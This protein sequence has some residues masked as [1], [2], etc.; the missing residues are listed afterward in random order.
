MSHFFLPATSLVREV[1]VSSSGPDISW[2]GG[3]TP[4]RVLPMIEDTLS[5]INIEI[6]PGQVQVLA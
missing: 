5:L 2:D 3:I 1:D 6:I 4:Y